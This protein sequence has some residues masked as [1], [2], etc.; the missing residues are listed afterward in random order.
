MTDNQDQ[1]TTYHQRPTQCV[2]Y[3][4]T[5]AVR[6][7]ALFYNIIRH[8]LQWCVDSSEIR[9]EMMYYVVRVKLYCN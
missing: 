7:T 2:H 1:Q 5:Y 4:P 9:I 6:N 3:N 8:S